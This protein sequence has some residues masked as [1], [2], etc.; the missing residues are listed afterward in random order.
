MIALGEPPVDI[1]DRST[2]T[3]RADA[4]QELN[5]LLEPGQQIQARP[6]YNINTNEY[7]KTITLDPIDHKPEFTLIFMHGLTHHLGG[8]V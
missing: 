7:S 5:K 1:Y 2:G 3:L 6:L 4:A 8:L